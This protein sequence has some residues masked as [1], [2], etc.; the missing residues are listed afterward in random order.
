MAKKAVQS[1]QE[2][3]D[4]CNGLS[5]DLSGTD[6]D[7]LP[8]DF[9]VQFRLDLSNCLHLSQ[10][11]INLAAGSLMLAGCKNLESLPD[12]LTTSFLD[13]SDCVRLR[14]W[15]E[16]AK[17]EAGRLRARNCVGLT[18][19][20][21]WL[22]SIAQLDVRGCTNLRELPDWLCVSSWIDLADT[23]VELLPPKL[24]NCGLRWKGVPIDERIAFHPETIKG[25]EVLQQ[26]NSELR[27]V[28]LER[29][30]FERFVSEVNAETLNTDS[31]AGGERRLLRIELPGDEPLVCVS[32]FC[33]STGRQYVIR[34]PP[35]MKTCHQAIAWTAGFDDPKLYQPL[36]ET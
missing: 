33:P 1:W 36:V 12:G 21:P 34:V 14:C 9:A 13:I 31:D 20:P 22:T 25:D 19:L 16:R 32:V 26:V 8:D 15:P 2:K 17:L 23:G 24:K 4:K 7:R 30:G 5:L 11:P 10:L 6:I 29:V 3:L 18:K 27:R 35:E 28:M